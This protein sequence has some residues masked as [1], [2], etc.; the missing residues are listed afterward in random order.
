MGVY[1]DGKHLIADTLIE[2][3]EYADALDMDRDWFVQGGIMFH[4]HYKLYGNTKKKVMA[5][6]SVLKVSTREIVRLCNEF[7]NFPVTEE[8][9]Y[10]WEMKHGRIP[11]PPEY[12]FKEI[13]ESIKKKIK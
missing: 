9:M 13:W 12:R 1:T 2:V 5:D 7:Y 3:M 8:E 10:Q 6:R 11:T 4:P